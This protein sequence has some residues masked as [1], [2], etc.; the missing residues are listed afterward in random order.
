MFNTASV[1]KLIQSLSFYSLPDGLSLQWSLSSA[2][3]MLVTTFTSREVLV[4]AHMSTRYVD[5]TQNDNY[6]VLS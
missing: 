2:V 5:T 3:S 4:T 6:K 1:K